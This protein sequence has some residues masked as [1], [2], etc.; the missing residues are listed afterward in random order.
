MDIFCESRSVS[1]AELRVDDDSGS[2]IHGEI[3][4]PFCRY[5]RTLPASYPIRNGRAKVIDPC[6]WTP[7]LPYRYELKLHVD[8]LDGGT[9]MHQFLWGLR[10]CVPHKADVWLNGKR[11]VLRAISLASED[12]GEVDLL[13]L[14]Q[15]ACSLMLK[16]PTN[17]ICE[18]ASDLGV[19]LFATSDS[20]TADIRQ[21]GKYPAVH[22]AF[23]KPNPKTDLVLCAATTVEPSGSQIQV[24][25]ET[26]LTAL[27]ST[28]TCRP[29]FVHRIVEP[30]SLSDMRKS[31]DWLQRDVASM[32]QFAG[33][34][35]SA[36][37]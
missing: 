14:R 37:A 22:F 18:E 35:I 21:W 3:R 33:Y 26:A 6:Y 7:S 19:M 4:G 23:A 1:L 29:R 10:W 30:S 13:Q 11:Y 12:A 9:V 36:N 5:A 2:Q 20:S 28:D 27:N 24:L 34:L 31:C 32:G 15:L 8:R 16:S 25:D 17:E